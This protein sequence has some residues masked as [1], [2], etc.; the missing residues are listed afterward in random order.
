MLITLSNVSTLLQNGHFPISSLLWWPFFVTIATVKA[1][2]IP[3]RSPVKYFYWPFQGGTSFA[4]HLC[5]F[6]LVF[7]ML[8]RLFIAALSSPAGKGLTSWLLFVLSN[9]GF[10]TSPCGILGQ[11]WYLIV[12]IPDLYR[13]S[14][15]F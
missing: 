7:V 4:D 10:V 5:V 2:T 11:V 9:C 8:S 12:L 14:Y 6:F 3:L 15:C 13:L 1:K